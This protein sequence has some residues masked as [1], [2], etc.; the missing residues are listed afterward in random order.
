MSTLALV[1]GLFRS[2]RAEVSRTVQ[3]HVDISL[4][5]D[6]AK[7]RT[8]E[9]ILDVITD[10]VLQTGPDGNNSV[11]FHEREVL[12]DRQHILVPRILWDASFNKELAGPSQK[13][14]AAREMLHQTD[15]ALRLVVEH[16]G[17]LDSLRWVDDDA[18]PLDRELA[19]GECLVKVKAWALNFKVGFHRRDPPRL[20]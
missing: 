13:P 19:V 2:I 18:Q 6:L 16:P 7:H 17:H 4:N 14:T 1:T 10:E 11:G 20:S 5:T 9:L 12:I 15:R 3:I 8:A